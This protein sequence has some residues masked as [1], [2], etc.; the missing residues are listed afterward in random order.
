MGSLTRTRDPG[1]I[2]YT[3]FPHLTRTDL[4]IGPTGVYW[5]RGLR[6]RNGAPGVLASLDISSSAH[7]DRVVTAVRSSGA[8]L[9]PDTPPVP[10]T[11]SDLQWHL[12]AR[13][14]ASPLITAR[15]TDVAALTF[16]LGRAGIGPGQQARISVQTDGPTTLG[17]TGLA[18]GQRVRVGSRTLFAS[19][20]G[21]A[22]V[23]LPAGVS[24]V[25][26]G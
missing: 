7:P 22:S 10:G 5:V 19:P 18:A 1:R 2:T 14:I 11:F 23:G 6:A 9:T 16:A 20:S 12:G 15:L 3:W 8:V 25:R 21:T 13:P 26:L 4:G 24:T 17:L